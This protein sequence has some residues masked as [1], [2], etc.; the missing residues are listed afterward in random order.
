M[1]YTLNQLKIF[2]TVARM[3]SVTKAAE[4]LHLTQP[5]VSVQLRN[6]QRQFRI[7]LTEAVGRQ[8]RVTEFGR[9]IARAA[10]RILSQAEEIRYRTE[11]FEGLLAGR[12]ILSSVSTG[13]YVMPYFLS[14]FLQEHPGI[15]LVMEMTNK[16]GVVKS[17]E[18]NLVDFSMVSILPHQVSVQSMELLENR[19]FLVGKGDA[20]LPP[21]R[22]VR[23]AFL[24]LPLI[25]REEGSGT[26]LIMEQFIRKHRLP[27]RKKMELTSNEA[28][29]HAILAGF[30]YS[31]LP[32]IGITE[33]L[34]NGRLRI[35]PVPGLP[36]KTAWNLIWLRDKQHSPVARAFLRY[37]ETGRTGIRDRHFSI[38]ASVPEEPPR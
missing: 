11:A 27:V 25:F 18:H 30:G 33:E 17:L 21:A 9:E 14:G 28:V 24:E 31:I 29:K 23:E 19:L 1:D 15:E 6:F 20:E 26:R 2:L 4:A 35:I 10:D 16:A 37:L 5:A 3:G 8:I 22:T 32:L 12:L 34:T 7:P 38:L 13:G 36:V